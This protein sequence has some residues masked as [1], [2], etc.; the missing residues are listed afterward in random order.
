MNAPAARYGTVKIIYNPNSTGDASK[1]AKE[2]AR[3][4]KRKI[5]DK[6][7]E[8]VPTEYP[9]HA[10][11]LAYTFAKRYKRPLIVSVSGDGGYHEVINGVLAAKSHGHA[12]EPVTAVVGAGNA[13]DHYRTVVKRPL[14]E[15]IDSEPVAIDL[16]KISMKEGRN[17]TVRYAHSYAGIGITPRIAEDLNRNKLHLF[18]ELHIISRALFV[19]RPVNIK[20]DSKEKRVESLLFA[21]IVQMAK[22]L[23][24]ND[25]NSLHDGKFEVVEIP[26]KNRLRLL[27]SLLKAATIGLKN[28]PRYSQFTFIMLENSPIQADGELAKV[29]NGTRITITVAKDALT[30]LL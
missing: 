9:G 13:N 10:E 24:L 2:T 18:K 12:K 29:K 11:K 23:K 27:S 20:Y 17:K 21:N 1:L 16:L 19:D 6:K 25:S 30:T 26:Y 5:A 22:V 8:L 3:D 7:I 14:A 15:A 4:L 28:Q